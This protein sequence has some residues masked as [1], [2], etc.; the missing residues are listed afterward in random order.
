MRMS[1]GVVLPAVACATVLISAFYLQ[2]QRHG[3]ER[4]KPTT[5]PRVDD[6]PEARL[7]VQL[8]SDVAVVKPTEAGFVTGPN[9]LPVSQS[10]RVLD[11][12]P[13][14]VDQTQFKAV[15][16]PGVQALLS[17]A[18]T[19]AGAGTRPNN[20]TTDAVEQD[21]FLYPSEPPTRLLLITP[22][23]PASSGPMS[24]PPTFS[25]PE[26]D[27]QFLLPPGV[28]EPA[29]LVA[30]G[31]GLPQAQ[32][33]ALEA[34]AEKFLQRLEDAVGK[35]VT[36]EQLS[37]VWDEAREEANSSF[38]ILFGDAAAN[39]RIAEAAIKALGFPLLAQQR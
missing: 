12:L 30:S 4:L 20:N 17:N 10:A 15:A 24:R 36:D 21:E 11:N 14:G 32:G 31:E 18:H 28:P 6:G 34:T 38:R 23:R 39:E 26:Q 8:S 5:R 22:T 37:E 27:L 25:R 16:A 19:I 3:G 9:P 13:S 29:A 1:P 2:E 35:A 7:R 33:N